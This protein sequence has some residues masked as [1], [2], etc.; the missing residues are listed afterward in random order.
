MQVNNSILTKTQQQGF[1][2]VNFNILKHQ[3]IKEIDLHPNGIKISS[4]AQNQEN[5]E[6]TEPLPPAVYLDVAGVP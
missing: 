4:K 6:L 1:F 2:N 5:S 3:T